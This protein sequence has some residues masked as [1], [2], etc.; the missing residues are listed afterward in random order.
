MLFSI[1][2]K[3]WLHDLDHHDEE[4]NFCLANHHTGLHVETKQNHCGVF[5]FDGTP[6]ELPVET[7]LPG[8]NV[9]YYNQFLRT[10][11]KDG[12]VSSQWILKLRGPPN[13]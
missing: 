7:K 4:I 6:Y 1:L 10:Q 8:A 11:I 2:P 9:F 13:A 12:I 3:E 5:Y